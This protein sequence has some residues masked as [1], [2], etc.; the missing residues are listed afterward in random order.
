MPDSASARLADDQKFEGSKAEF[1]EWSETQHDRWDQETAQTLEAE[2]QEWMK[3][4]AKARA[5]DEEFNEPGPTRAEIEQRFVDNAIDDLNRLEAEIDRMQV[6]SSILLTISG[7]FFL[8]YNIKPGNLSSVWGIGGLVS[9]AIALVVDAVAFVWIISPLAPPFQRSR[10]PYDKRTHRTL[11]PANRFLKWA[12]F[13]WMS[14]RRT[15]IIQKYKR[16]HAWA[17]RLLKWAALV[18]IPGIVLG[19]FFH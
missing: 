14:E 4:S 12:H 13:C 7:A 17:V 11:L 5:R 15:P 19:I 10:K 16:A 2:L 9:I 18:A 1:L 6:R 8:I 3:E